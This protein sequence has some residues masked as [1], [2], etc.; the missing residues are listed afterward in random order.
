MEDLLIVDNVDLF[1]GSIQALHNI[2]FKVKKGEIVSLIGA[3]GAGKTSTLRAISS[4]EK[5]K[6]GSIVYDGKRLDKIECHNVVELGICHVPEGRHVFGELT[7]FENLKMGAF[8][9]NDKVE[10]KE[11]LVKIMDI[12]PRLKERRNQISATLS[13]G[14]QQ[15]LAIARAMMGRPEL[16]ILDEPS[17]GL[18]PQIIDQILRIIVDINNTG[19]TIL[20]V[21]QNAN[22]ALAISDY[23]YVLETGRIVMEDDALKLLANDDVKK[24]YLGG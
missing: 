11:D 18:A 12:F 7:V 2:S 8:L 17:M 6:N 23:A 20:L 15:M 16:L 22:A 4:L 14:E 24:A 5:I 10:V 1:Y 13:G 9:R 3:N 21:E 19:T